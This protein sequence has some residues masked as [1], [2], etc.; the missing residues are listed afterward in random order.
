[1]RFRELV[2]RNIASPYGMTVAAL[3]LFLVAFMFPPALY[4]SYMQEPDLMFFDPASLVFFLTCTMAFLLGL[5]LVDF[6]F[7]VRGFRYEKRET[8]FSSMWFILFPIIAGTALSILSSILLLRSNTYLLELLLAAQGGQLKSVGGIE[9]QDT[10]VQATPALMGIVWWAIWR[11]DQF[12]F[13][14]WRRVTVHSAIILATLAM[15]LWSVLLLTRGEL[16]PI[17]A[18]IATLFLLRRLMRKDLRPVFVLKFAAIGISSIVALFASFSALRG[19]ADLETITANILGYTIAS[20][21]RLAAILEGRLR[22]PFS[23]KGL[24]FS[25]FVSFN[26]TFNGLFHVNKIFSW[27]DFITVWQS[28]FGAVSAA[29]LDGHLILS[30]TFGYIFSEIGW[31]SPLLLLVYG[32]IT[33]WTWRSLKLGKTVGI[34]LYPWCAYSVLTWFGTNSLLEPTAVILLLDVIVLGLYESM[35]VRPLTVGQG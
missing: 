31:L 13:R 30:G 22:Y 4:S 16:V 18:G 10:M 27:P 25:G 34:V 21:N 32:L 28:E 15:L 20:Y 12:S 9:A 23:G 7:P 2:I 35:F 8:R 3:L 1:M 5:L 11:K 33:G 6:A 17:F 14:G 19:A 24:Y 26:R 29:G